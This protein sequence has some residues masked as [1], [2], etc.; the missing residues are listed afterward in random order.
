MIGENQCDGC[1][2][3]LPTENQRGY[4]VH[5]DPNDP[6]Y[7]IGC[8]KFLYQNFGLYCAVQEVRYKRITESQKKIPN[9]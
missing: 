1:C 8:T 5:Y 3:L 2:R 9:P 7:A 6:Y 4:E